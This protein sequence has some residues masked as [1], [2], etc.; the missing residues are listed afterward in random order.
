MRFGLIPTHAGKT[1]VRATLTGA[2]EAHP[3]SRGEN[4]ASWRARLAVRGSSPLT[5]GKPVQA[6]LRV[7][8]R[9]LI[10]THAGKTLRSA[11]ERPPQRAHPH[12]R[13]EN[14]DWCVGLAAQAGSSPL[15]RGKPRLLGFIALISGLI[16]T[17]AGKTRSS[18]RRARARTAHPHSRGENADASPISRRAT[19]S[20]PLTR[21]KPSVLAGGQTVGG[22]IP[23]H[24]GKTLPYGQHLAATWAH[25]HSRGENVVARE[26]GAHRVG[27]S[28]LTRGKLRVFPPVGRERGLIPTHAGKT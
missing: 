12:S 4:S 13:G 10:P 1:L 27:S 15:T 28:P 20:S 7:A 19:G 2:E 17:H 25:P 8:D 24:A 16:P 9:G 22:L 11:R 23:T 5:R 3:H 26:R 21:G 6:E 18:A 14:T